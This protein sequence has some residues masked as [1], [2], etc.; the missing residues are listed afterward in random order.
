V[1]Y[2]EGKDYV[3]IDTFPGTVNKMKVIKAAGDLGI[4]IVNSKGAQRLDTIKTARLNVQTI[5]DQML[6]ILPAD[7]RERLTK[8]PEIFLSQVFQTNSMRGA[9]HTFSLAAYQHLG[10]L[11]GGQG[12]GFRQYAKALEDAKKYDIP[13]MN[14]S[15]E[16]AIQ[17]LNNLLAL[18]DDV[19]KPLINYG[20]RD[21]KGPLGRVAAVHADSTQADPLGVRSK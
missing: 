8:A 5:L 16:T 18:F 4:P 15:V 7:P 10:A 6:Q 17:K 2:G 12:T 11:A 19:E 20:Y 13:T 9:F 3:N 1:K 21:I 14:D